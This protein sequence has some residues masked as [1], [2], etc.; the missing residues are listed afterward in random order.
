MHSARAPFSPIQFLQTKKEL[1]KRRERTIMEAQA[2]W[3][4]LMMM[5]HLLRSKKERRGFSLIL[6]REEI[7]LKMHHRL[8]ITKPR[9][10]P[11]HRIQRIKKSKKNPW[12]FKQ[13]HQL[14]QLQKKQLNQNDYS[15]KHNK[16]KKKENHILR[17]SQLP[18]LNFKQDSK[19]TILTFQLWNKNWH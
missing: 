5:W 17:K 6:V 7:T 1:E 15:W 14:K 18:T 11:F 13:N 16:D 9:Q 19:P 4:L 2:G 3:Y 10:Q 12:L 8:K